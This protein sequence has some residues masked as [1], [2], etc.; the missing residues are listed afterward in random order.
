MMSFFSLLFAPH[1]AE[2]PVRATLA[3]GQVL[4]GEVRTRIL[5]LETGAGIL[6]VPLSDVGEVVPASG[7]P[8]GVAE[9][10][11]NVW[12]R[13]GSELRGRWSDP[14]LDMGI[15][16]GGGTVAVNLPM[17]ELSRF[18]LS[19]GERWPGGAV[20]RMRTSWGDDFLVD[21]AKTT[22]VIENQLGSFA[23]LLTECRYVAPVTEDPTGDWRVELSTGTVLIGAL[24]DSSLT[25]ALPMGPK[26]VT[27]PLA[28]F[29]SLELQSWQPATP[30]AVQNYPTVHA[31]SVAR[32]APAVQ[33]EKAG[34]TA[35]S[36]PA[37]EDAWFD[38]QALKRTKDAAE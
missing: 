25:V 33:Q 38:A 35:A 20:Y 11:V 6:E 13:N 1:P 15:S 37:Q 36:A 2:T 24:R 30:V 23:P 7:D 29:V 4:M 16:V 32:G 31:E 19:G 5:R 27:V 14:E 3:D 22:L 21:P 17:N 26:E 10:Q 18:Q 8:L 12:L 9:G 34:R 28:N